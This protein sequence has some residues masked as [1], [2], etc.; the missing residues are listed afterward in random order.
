MSY[1]V[2][3]NDSIQCINRHIYTI[4]LFLKKLK[5][6]IQNLVEILA[7]FSMGERKPACHYIPPDFDPSK[8]A[9]RCKPRNGQHQVRFMLPFS[10]QCDICGDYL[11]QG[12]KTN[13]RKE[14]VYDEFYLGINVYRI[15]LHCKSCYAEITIK[16]DPKN[17]DYIVEKGATRNFE[18]WRKLQLEQALEEK[19][20]CLG[21]VIQ[22]VEESTVDTQREMDQLRELERLRATSQKRDRA[23]LENILKNRD[24]NDID[25]TLT[26][27]DKKKL[28][29]F[30]KDKQNFVKQKNQFMPTKLISSNPFSKNKNNSSKSLLSYGDDTSDDSSD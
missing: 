14:L 5:V 15:Y 12:T 9:R 7:K 20:K 3:N 21:N 11:F 23:N 19:K 24:N 2:Y 30:E 29:T 18:P 16:T 28:E 22:Q 13:S 6:I 26:E 27:E 17:C 1:L 25:A 8:P 4:F 10:I